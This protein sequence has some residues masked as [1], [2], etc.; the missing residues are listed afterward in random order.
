MA[1]RKLTPAE[2]EAARRLLQLWNAKKQGLGLTQAKA[3]E[4]FDFASHTAIYQYLHG[5]IPMGTDAVIKFAR[6]LNVEA[7]EIRP[8]LAEKF[9]VLT[10]VLANLGN[11]TFE[12]SN[13][14]VEI[15]EILQSIS[16]GKKPMAKKML[17][18]F[19]TH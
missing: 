9:D 13:E 16:R 5:L 19:A 4:A 17:Q 15:F 10:P 11:R 7:K 8:D 3:A 2:Q 1:K 6:L 14:D 18:A 12:L